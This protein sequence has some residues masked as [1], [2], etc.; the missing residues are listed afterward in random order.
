MRS[1]TRKKVSLKQRFLSKIKKT[2]T[3]WI[4]AAN[5]WRGYGKI[6][7]NNINYRAHR[8]AY[9][10]FKGAIPKGK[11]VCHTCDNPSCCNPKHLFLGSQQENIRDM[12]KKGRQHC[13]NQLGSAN[14]QALLNEQ[15]VSDIKKLLLNKTFTIKQISD[16]Y[17]TKYAT[18]FDI[19]RLK[20]WRHVK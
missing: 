3:C 12:V 19:K 14:S 18:I 8:V 6:R 16:M 10:L 5:K 13:P 1:K 2:D 9:E 17:N 7:I 15:K 11:L 20:T 4:W